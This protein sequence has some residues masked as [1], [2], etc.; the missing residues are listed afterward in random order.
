RGRLAPGAA[1]GGAARRLLEARL[2]V[3]DRL[4]AALERGGGGLGAVAARPRTARARGR[5]S[6]HDGEQEQR[7]AQHAEID[8]RRAVGIHG[9]SELTK[10]SRGFVPSCGP[11][12]PSCSICSIMRAAR[13]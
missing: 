2:E 5:R 4:V 12:I 10:T 11:T 1:E 8:A 6:A 7:C 3:A 9:S 13:L